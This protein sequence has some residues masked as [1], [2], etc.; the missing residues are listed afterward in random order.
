MSRLHCPLAVGLAS[1]LAFATARAAD[2]PPDPLRSVKVPEGWKLTIFAKQPEVGY[3]TSISV[4]LDG[5]A[6]V[7]IDEN[8]S[9]DAKP[10]RGR[11]VRCIDSDGDGVADK[12]VTVA[13]MDSPRG[14]IWEEHGKGG[15][16]YVM[17]PPALTAYY[18]ADG[19]G[20]AEKQEDLVTGLAYDLTFRGADHTTNGIRLGID[21]WIYIACGDYGAVAA[22]G[23]DGR[24]FNM[25]GGGIVRVRPD[26]TGLE[27]VSRG[28]RNVYDVA[29]SPTLDL[30]T[31][32]N[33]NDGGGWNDRFSHV[34]MGANYG[35][36][37]LF[38][39]FPDEMIQPL[40]DYGSGSPTGA[41]WLDEPS[42]PTAMQGLFTLEWGRNNI[43]HHLVKP[44]GASWKDDPK[45]FM[46]L[47]RPTDIDVDAAGNLYVTIWEGATYTYNGPL[48]G[49][50]IRL[51]KADATPQTVPDLQ[52]ASDTDLA[53]LVGSESGIL[54]LAAQRELLRRPTTNVAKDLIKLATD[55]KSIGG[56]VAAIFTL[57]QLYGAKANDALVGLAQND[58]VR[59]FALRAL[60]DDLRTVDSVPVQPFVAA[61]GDA[62]SRV[63]L[64]AVIAL[65]RLGK[66]QIA[67]NSCR[68]P[69]MPIR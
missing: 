68:S 29:I 19:D 38:R 23:K 57:K 47:T 9:L 54:R 11:V 20:V 21:G 65:G 6:F 42:L 63:R 58:G 48:A 45:E 36:P 64:Q 33:T 61:L 35:Y 12:F 7:A 34:V 3:P 2:A 26:G 24:T 18:D 8:S 56:Q 31:R 22:K 52:K 51:T 14:V 69:P 37:S 5:T 49:Y 50:V 41:I 43:T 44:N 10:D 55:A 27:F 13:K 60:A 32:D 28:Q 4:A 15:T 59:E 16:L 25:K 53:K 67:P 46:K 62:N 40:A 30:F 39:N 66:K 17:H 1:L